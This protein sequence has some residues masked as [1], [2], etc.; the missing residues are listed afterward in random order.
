MIN[1]EDPIFELHEYHR[2][3][4]NLNGDT[5]FPGTKEYAFLDWK[6]SKKAQKNSCKRSTSNCIILKFQDYFKISRSIFQDFKI[7]ISRKCQEYF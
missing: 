4:N 5:T 6:H 2:K 3:H 1:P 7:N